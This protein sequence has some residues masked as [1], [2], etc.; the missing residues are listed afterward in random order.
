[1]GKL[2]EELGIEPDKRYCMTKRDLLQGNVDLIRH[3]VKLLRKK[4]IYSLS[5]E[6]FRRKA[7]RG[8]RVTCASKIPTTN[9]KENISYLD[10]YL[11]DRF[12]QTIDAKDGAIKRKPVILKGGRG[13]TRV[14]V[15]AYDGAKNLVAACRHK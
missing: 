6:R 1:V 8:V 13:R 15:Q 4:P 7:S 11:N 2:L 12:H 9:T 14:L 5:L 10:V 3:A